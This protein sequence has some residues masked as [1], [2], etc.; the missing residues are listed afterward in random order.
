MF[1]QFSERNPRSSIYADAIA[2]AAACSSTLDN[3]NKKATR[4]E[5]KTV[6]CW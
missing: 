4:F 3:K 2:A 1:I 6:Y 5:N